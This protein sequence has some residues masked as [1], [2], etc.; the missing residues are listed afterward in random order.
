VHELGWE[1]GVKSWTSFDSEKTC[2]GK[3]TLMNA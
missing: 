1:Q 3:E 2:Q